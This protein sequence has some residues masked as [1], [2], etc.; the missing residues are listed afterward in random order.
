M[1]CFGVFVLLTL[2]G[3]GGSLS[4]EQRRQLREAQEHQAIRRINE[5]D[6]LAEAFTRGREIAEILRDR[7]PE[8]LPLDSIGQ[9]N[10][11]VIRWRALAHSDAL[12]IERQLIE[13]YVVAASTGSAIADNVQRLGTDTLLYTLPITRYRPDSVLEVAGVWSIRMATRNVVLGISGR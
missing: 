5:A 2:L 13:A 9:A 12:D 8:E 10:Q 7:K 4:E 3:C 6:L 1:R 11:V